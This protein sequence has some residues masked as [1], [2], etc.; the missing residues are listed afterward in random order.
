MYQVRSKLCLI[1]FIGSVP[2]A[3]A[4][5]FTR[6][7]A[8]QPLF[9]LCHILSG[10]RNPLLHLFTADLKCIR[11]ILKRQAG[12]NKCRQLRNILF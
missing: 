6:Q 8:F 10:E 3:P 4:D 1:A 2:P 9:E 7:K 12:M 11:R 5:R